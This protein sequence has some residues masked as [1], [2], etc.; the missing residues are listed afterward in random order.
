MATREA[1]CVCGQLVVQAEG[2]PFAV[3][4]CN[5]LACQRRTGSAFGMQAGYNA[6]QVKVAGRYKDY[7]R[8]SD[9]SDR[10]E[11]V[12]H[13]C[14]E[15]GSQVFYTEPTEPDLVVVAIGA[16][17][18]PSFPPPTES[19]YDHHRH[20][21]V[22]LP[23]TV[24]RSTS[25][26]WDSVRPLYEA[27]KYDEA[28]EAGRELLVQ[29]P[30]NPRLL[31]NVACCEPRRSEGGGD[32]ASAP[33]NRGLRRAALARTR[34]LGLRRDPRRPRLPGAGGLALR[35]LRPG[36]WHWQAPHPDWESSEPWGPEVS[37][38][39]VVDGAGRL[40]L[41][42]PLGARAEL[43]ELAAGRETAILLTVPWHERDTQALVSRHGWPV[44]APRPE[45]EDDL[46]QRFGVSREQ[47]AGG[48]PDLRW[49]MEDDSIEKHLLEPGEV[50]EGGV[51]VFPGQK[52]PNEVVFWVESHGAVIAGDTLVDFGNGVEINERWLSGGV[53]REQVAEPLR[54]L[55]ARPVELML[56]THGLPTDRA[57]LERALV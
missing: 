15:C 54:P 40:L 46:M 30:G 12:F 57:A 23:D 35:E 16:F 3:S 49:L 6:D 14:P 28:A 31:Y 13:F 24:E 25:Q 20:P 42:D 32:R 19:G 52:T 39:A 41:F 37:S 17:A 8:I 43:E 9:E 4:I 53:T 21:W 22:G 55:L 10:K 18:D 56:P 5:C 7:S 29:Y 45:S 50:L 48:S 36:L 2:E 11:H 44:Y 34:R 38:Y 26:V 27:G 47:V 1:A 33:R 51:E